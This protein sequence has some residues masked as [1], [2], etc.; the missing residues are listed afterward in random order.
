[1]K[2]NRFIKVSILFL[3]L[4]NIFAG[5]DA[6]F[7]DEQ[8]VEPGSTFL[9]DNQKASDSEFIHSLCDLS[10]YLDNDEDKSKKLGV[11]H[12]NVHTKKPCPKNQTSFIRS[13]DFHTS[14][15]ILFESDS[16]PPFK[17]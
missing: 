9:S 17:A 5:G 2:M 11:T 15:F 14:D 3:F 6:S 10:I 16:S 8:N 12:S 13:S 4:Q 1:M 7:A